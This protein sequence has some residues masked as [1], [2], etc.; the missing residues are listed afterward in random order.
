MPVSLLHFHVSLSLGRGRKFLA[1]VLRVVA[2]C[3]QV[4]TGLLCLPVCR[5]HTAT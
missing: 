2:L 5:Y 1:R 3:L 4:Q